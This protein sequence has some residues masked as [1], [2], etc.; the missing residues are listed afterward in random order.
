MRRSHLRM[1]CQTIEIILERSQRYHLWRSS[2]S[3]R[4]ASSRQ[5]KTKSEESALIVPE[6]AQDSLPASDEARV[7][8]EAMRGSSTGYG[9]LLPAKDELLYFAGVGAMAVVGLLEWPVA[10]VAA[11]AVALMGR[12]KKA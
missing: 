6:A 12:R 7:A 8:P 11:G 4:R 5:G 10:L 1:H 9:L 2:C 3:N